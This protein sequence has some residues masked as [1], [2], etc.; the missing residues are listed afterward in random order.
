[1]DFITIA[2]VGAATI[3]TIV[4]FSAFIRQ[5]FLSRDKRLNDEAQ[6]IALTQELSNLEDMRK[7][8][9]NANRFK[10]HHQVIGDSKESIAYVELKI[11]EL[12]YKKKLLVEKYCLLITEELSA[13]NPVT[14]KAVYDKLKEGIDEELAFCNKELEEHQ[15]SRAMLWGKHTD[16]QTHLLDDEKARNAALDQLYLTHSVVMEKIYL[17]HIEDVETVSKFSIEAGNASFASIITAPLQFLASLFTLS[18]GIV[19]PVANIQLVGRQ[20]VQQN[21]NFIN[22]PDSK[23][24]LEVDSDTRLTMK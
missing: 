11:N 18:S 19:Y 3:G 5:L 24:E 7:E 13:A 9:L 10:I 23:N 2:L 4:A 20:E 22:A 16:F 6:R 15:K 12:L 14:K 1:M 8:L 17:R 21:Q